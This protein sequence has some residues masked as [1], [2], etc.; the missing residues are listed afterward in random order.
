M[1][2]S[3][4]KRIQVNAEKNNATAITGRCQPSGLLFE[5]QITEWTQNL[6]HD[7]YFSPWELGGEKVKRRLFH[8]C[9]LSCGNHGSKNS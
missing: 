6:G 7:F 4:G 2:Y 9:G 3:Y 5:E 1:K 8:C